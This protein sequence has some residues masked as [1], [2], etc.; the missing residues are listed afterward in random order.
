MAALPSAGKT[1]PHARG[2]KFGRLDYCQQVIESEVAQIRR[3][4]A[5]PLRAPADAHEAAAFRFFQYPIGKL[6]GQN[7]LL[8]NLLG[9][10]QLVS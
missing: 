10:K 3:E 2:N 1:W 7:F 5:T 9:R 6:Q 8:A 4:G